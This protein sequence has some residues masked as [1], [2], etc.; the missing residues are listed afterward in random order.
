MAARAGAG[1]LV[2]GDGAHTGGEAGEAGGER[3]EKGAEALGV[4]GRVTGGG[5]GVEAGEVFL[6][7]EVFGSEPAG[8]IDEVFVGEGGGVPCDGEAIGESEGGT[9]GAGFGDG[10]EEGDGAEAIIRARE[11]RKGRAQGQR[12]YAGTGGEDDGRGEGVGR[13]G[14]GAEVD[15]AEEAG[16][17][18][19][20]RGR[21]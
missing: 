16:E 5:V 4:G 20:V 17:A 18:G 8:E 2:T 11:A 9:E 19:I 6:G 15:A 14:E 13:V 10:D 3:S 1:G 7:E 12:G 21:V